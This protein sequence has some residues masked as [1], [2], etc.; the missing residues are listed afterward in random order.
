MA[1][2]SA[3]VRR[4][5]RPRPRLGTVGSGRG[6]LGLPR[7]GSAGG[8]AISAP[9]VGGVRG[10]EAMTPFLLVLLSFLGTLAF[11]RGFLDVFRAFPAGIW[12]SVLGSLSGL[13][14]G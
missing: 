4:R 2:D 6:F 9:I 12:G 3:C 14:T 1:S 7:M 13:S 10:F 5:G 11:L 8:N